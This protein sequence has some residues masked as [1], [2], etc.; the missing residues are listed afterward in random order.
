MA[1]VLKSVRLST[2]VRLSYLEQ[3]DPSGTPVLFLHG[4]LDSGRSFEPV[5]A[6]LPLNLQAFALTQRGHGDT[7]RPA[8]GYGLP[9]FAAD[10]TAFMDALG[11]A[12]AVVV[13]HSMGSAVALRFAINHPDR[14]L[15]LVLVG[16]SNTARGNPG[17]RQFWESTLARL[18]DPV[19]PDFVR[20]LL[21][22]MLVQPVPHEFFEMAVQ[23]SAKVPPFVWRETLE[24]RWHGEGDFS[25]EL[26]K[27]TAPTLIVWGDRDPRYPRSEQEA[28]VAAIPRSRLVVYAGAGHLLHWEEPHR[29]ASDL[30]SFIGAL[31][32]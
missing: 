31:D 22:D 24:A 3:G 28:L 2:Q 9:D 23:E 17:A 30:G 21:R 5:L 20:A 4:F 11:I 16:A 10:L 15:G 12:A 14:V 6:H 26:G 19:D 7:S 1:S 18:T 29:F 13:G 27:V 25:G 8:S 32:T